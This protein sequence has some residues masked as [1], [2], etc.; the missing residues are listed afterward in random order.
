MSNTYYFTLAKSKPGPGGVL[1]LAP[2]ID[3]AE[4]VGWAGTSSDKANLPGYP[5]GSMLFCIA[6]TAPLANPSWPGVSTATQGQVT[7]WLQRT[8]DPSPENAAGWLGGA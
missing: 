7:S 6:T 2:D 8:G 3:P 1:T 5:N 4:T